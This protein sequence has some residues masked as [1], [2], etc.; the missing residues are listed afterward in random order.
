MVKKNRKITKKSLSKKKAKQRILTNEEK[1]EIEKLINSPRTAHYKQEKLSYDEYHDLEFQRL[2]QA[3]H[4]KKS[5]IGKCKNEFKIES[6]VRCVSYQ[7]SHQPLSSRGSIY[8][9]GGRFNIGCDIKEEQFTHFNA[10]YIAEDTETSL[11]EK[12]GVTL[13]G[14]LEDALT[15]CFAKKENFAS[16]HV[17]GLLHNVL[18][19][20]DSKTLDGFA[21]LISKIN[22]SSEIVARRKSAGSKSVGTIKTSS[23]LKKSLYEL[24]WR[25]TPQILDLPSNSQIFGQIAFRAGVEAVLYS[26]VK[27]GKK[28]LA[29]FLKNLS[30]KSY[31]EVSG[32]CPAN[33]E[34]KRV[35]ATNYKSCL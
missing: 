34:I 13:D 12:F 4:L 29:V 5:L 6:W 26:S 23:D 25:F 24:D 28:C 10:L 15:A 17:K 35:D 21:E 11:L 18:D 9:I 8:S 19:L 27:T 14:N 16:I 2:T 20:D 32:I 3:D 22:F 30:D 33:V 1:Y 31:I 7:F